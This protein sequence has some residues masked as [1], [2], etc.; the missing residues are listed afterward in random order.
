MPSPHT[1]TFTC[2]ETHGSFLKF[3]HMRYQKISRG[4]QQAQFFL[5]VIYDVGVKKEVVIKKRGL[6]FSLS[7]VS[8]Y[9][10]RM[11][12]LAR[13]SLDHS[14][15]PSSQFTLFSYITWWG[16]RHLSLDTTWVITA[17]LIG[18]RC[19]I[20][21]HSSGVPKWLWTQGSTTECF[22]IPLLLRMLLWI[23]LRNHQQ[24]LHEMCIPIPRF[25][26]RTMQTF[27]TSLLSTSHPIRPAWYKAPSTSE[28]LA[29]IWWDITSGS[30]QTWNLWGLFLQKQS[31]I[32]T[33]I[34]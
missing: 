26:W 33:E 1:E 34:P 17:S 2:S 30:S 27:Q 9:R 31:S 11:N 10:W 19:P 4:G 6:S 28:A 25:S 23:L 3:L 20:S 18:A 5:W 16:Q 29:S 14:Q 8:A 21:L 13:Y 32:Q 22:N 12:S 15:F 24:Y 7:L